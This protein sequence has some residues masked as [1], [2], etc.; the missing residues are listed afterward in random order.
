[1]HHK[2]CIVDNNITI[3]GSYNWTYYA[4]SRNIENVLITDDELIANQYEKEFVSIIGPSGCGKSTLGRTILKVHEPDGGH[5]YFEGNDI[6]KL[7]YN[8]MHPYRRK[9]QMIFQDPYSSLNPSMT[10]GQ[11][12]SEPIR[13]KRSSL[14]KIEIKEK[15]EEERRGEKNER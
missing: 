10:I 4:E 12:I 8:Q 2:F 9:M 14:T 7:N 11:I 1:M 15:V 5:I 3:T 13:N 6:T